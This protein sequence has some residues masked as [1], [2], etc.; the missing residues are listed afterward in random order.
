MKLTTKMALL[1]GLMVAAG[2]NA[3]NPDQGRAYAADLLSD[4]QG[5]ASLLA[6]GGTGP[7]LGGFITFRWMY[8]SR[9]NTP[10]TDSQDGTTGFQ[11]RYTKL[12]LKGNLNEA[13]SY[14]I[15]AAFN[16][17]GGDFTLDD[18]YGQYTAG[19]GWSIKFG[20]FKVPLLREELVKDTNQLAYDRSVLNNT[21]SGGRSQG[22][23]FTYESEM[24]RFRGM[25][26]DGANQLNS[27]IDEETADFGL[28]GRFEYKGAGDWK[29]FEDFTSWQ[30]ASG[31]AWLI[32]AAAH[33]QTGGSTF[34]DNGAGKT[35]ETDIIIYTI[36][37]SLEG[38][39]WNAY[40]AFVGSRVDPDGGSEADDFGFLV[41]GGIFVAPQNELYARVDMLMPDGDRANDE[42]FTTITAGWNHYFVPESHAAKLNISG[43]FFLD[44]QSESDLALPSTATGLLSSGDDSQFA[45]LG[46]IQLLF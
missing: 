10:G 41:Q 33:F 5:R 15:Q 11:S 21:F 37:G 40:A 34:Q 43:V 13:W 9:D 38:Q 46:Q 35:D 22:V 45:L 27:D 39:G 6:D 18:A 44:A 4:A 25:L 30:S 17:S 20:Q 14:G 26:N 31:F 1:A 7:E 16:R 2:A 19:T 32:G 42:T 3:Q 36:D 23:Q 12:W 8:N 29:Q 28:T 24:W